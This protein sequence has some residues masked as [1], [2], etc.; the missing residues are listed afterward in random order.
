M[1]NGLPRAGSD[2]R[3]FGWHE[4]LTLDVGRGRLGAL[5]KRALAKRAVVDFEGLI[6]R[7]LD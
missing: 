3:W 7:D 6:G 2:A 5:V 1:R 4:T